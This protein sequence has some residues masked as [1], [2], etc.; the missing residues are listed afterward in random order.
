MNKRITDEEKSWLKQS[1]ERQEWTYGDGYCD[2]NWRLESLLESEQ[3][4]WE[5]VERLK[6]AVGLMH[7]HHGV[8]T[9]QVVD[10]VKKH[11][12]SCVE[13]ELSIRALKDK[14]QDALN[15]LIEVSNI[16]IG[17]L[18]EEAIDVKYKAKAA[19]QRIQEG[20]NG[21]K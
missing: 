9:E 6:E 7:D 19:I 8:L 15:T 13:H 5:E 12:K 4:G 20:K 2:E 3:V 11:A 17:G 21:G 14:L 10:E 16:R 18:T 1:I